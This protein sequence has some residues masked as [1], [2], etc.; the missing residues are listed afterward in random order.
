MF[1]PQIDKTADAGVFGFKLIDQVLAVVENPDDKP[2]QWRVKQHKLPF[3]EFGP[4]RER[5]WGSASWRKPGLFTSTVTTSSA[6]RKRYESLDC[7]AAPAK[8][9]DDFTAWRFFTGKDWSDKPAD[10]TALADGLATEFS[11]GR[12][13]D[14]KGY[15]TVYTE[16]GL[17]DRILGRFAASPAGPWSPPLLLYKCPEM[18]KDKGVFSYAGKAHAWA[19]SGNELVVSYCVN[20]W[21]FARLFREDEVYRPRFVRVKLGMAK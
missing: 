4:D 2:E 16:S 12:L 10:A 19:A 13:P 11:V 18:A 5:S 3:V 6:G 15:V 14:R 1:L 20:T 9:I 17:G 7:R 8:K 21:E